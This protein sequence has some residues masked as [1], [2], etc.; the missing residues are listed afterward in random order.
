[1]F[2]Y[3]EVERSKLFKEKYLY[4]IYFNFDMYWSKENEIWYNKEHEKCLNLIKK[5]LL[6][7]FGNIFKIQGSVIYCENLDIAFYIRMIYWDKIK[8][9]EKAVV[10]ND[11][12]N[13]EDFSIN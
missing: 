5:E 11:N 13:K 1:M 10:V 3:K 12:E 2:T 7:K 4:K 6:S 8:L 9:I